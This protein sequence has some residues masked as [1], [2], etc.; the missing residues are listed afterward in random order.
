MTVR[1]NRRRRWLRPAC[2][3]VL[4]CVLIYGTLFGAVLA[5][6]HTQV[7]GQP[8]IMLILGCQVYPWG[9]SILLQD[10]LDTAIAYLENHP[11]MTV[12]VTGGQGADEPVSEAACMKDYLIKQGAQAGKILMEEDS[13]NTWQN[14]TCSSRLMEEQ[15]L[16]ASGGVLIVSSGLHLTRARMLWHRATGG[17]A[18]TVAA[19]ATHLPSRLF[20]GV[21]EPLALA[22]SLLIDR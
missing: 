14:M 9:P 6:D 5:G 19:P 20:M 1:K 17:K 13:S 22:K 11:G 12:I 7:D 16:D 2:A 3:V 18:N 21:R 10:R 8:Q 15:G 4:A